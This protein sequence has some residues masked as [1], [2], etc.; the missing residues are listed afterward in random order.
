VGVEKNPHSE[1]EDWKSREEEYLMEIYIEGTKKGEKRD[2]NALRS[3]N[4]RG[5]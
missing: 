2:I 5:A 4:E 3:L 1:D